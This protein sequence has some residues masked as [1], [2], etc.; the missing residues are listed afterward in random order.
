MRKTLSAALGRGHLRS[1][2]RFTS[3][4]AGAECYYGACA[5]A[6]QDDG[7]ALQGEYGLCRHLR[8][9]RS[10]P[11]ECTYFTIV[12][13]PIARMVS[14]YRYFCQGC[15]EACRY[16]GHPAFAHTPFG[17]RCPNVL[18]LEYA[19]LIG[20]LYTNH[21]S[22]AEACAPCETPVFDTENGAPLRHGAQCEGDWLSRGGRPLA[23]VEP[24]L[25]ARA[26]AAFD[27]DVFPIVLED[28]SSDRAGSPR[29]AANMS[30][31]HVLRRRF[32]WKPLLKFARDSGGTLHVNANP[33]DANEEHALN[34]TEL[35]LLKRMLSPD[36]EVFEHA[37]GIFR[38]FVSR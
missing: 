36:L 29:P 19:S 34:T 37:R 1:V 3:M 32:N 33:R 26:K 10:G 28:V 4:H 12:R 25:V 11:S 9:G 22:G 7:A 20:N 15:A 31:A 24:A 27:R 23:E 21:F 2:P 16:C 6:W 38:S 35:A 14:G 5:R 18:L 13:D 8:S 30:I 17:R